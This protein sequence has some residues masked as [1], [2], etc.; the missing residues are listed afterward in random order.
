MFDVIR[1][2]NVRPKILIK[3]FTNFDED[4]ILVLPAQPSQMVLFQDRLEWTAM[5][6]MF[7]EK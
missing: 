3:D 5:R 2:D 1:Q 6:N 7:T 4:F